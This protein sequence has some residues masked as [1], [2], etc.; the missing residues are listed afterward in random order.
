MIRDVTDLLGITWRVW[1]VSAPAA[2]RQALPPVLRDG[3]LA[4][5]SDAERR[6]LGPVPPDWESMSEDALLTLLAESEPFAARS[7]ARPTPTD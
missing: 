3:W 6:R 1:V 5:Q 2:R 7:G 4:F